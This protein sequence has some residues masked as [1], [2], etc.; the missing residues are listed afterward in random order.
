MASRRHSPSASPYPFLPLD[1]LCRYYHPTNSI[2]FHYHQLL[3]C[4][5]YLSCP[6]FVISLLSSDNTSMSL[7]DLTHVVVLCGNDKTGKS[8]TTALLNQYFHD[9]SLSM[10][11]FERSTQPPDPQLKQLKELICPKLIDNITFIHPF[12]KRPPIPWSV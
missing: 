7:S 6:S 5:L 12:E 3:V 1:M 9:N 10:Y 4:G 8:S 11:A 2:R